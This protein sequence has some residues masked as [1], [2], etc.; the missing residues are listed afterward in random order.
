M[1]GAVGAPAA[2]IGAVMCLW[3]VLPQDQSLLIVGT[4]YLLPG[5]CILLV[6]QVFVHLRRKSM[7]GPS[8]PDSARDGIALIAVLILLALLSGLVT[9]SLVFASLALRSSET[10]ADRSRVRLAASDAM[11]LG[12]RRLVGTSARPAPVLLQDPSGI[13]ARVRISAKSN[14]ASGASPGIGT[15]FTLRASASGPD[16]TAHIYCRARREASGDLR[17]VRWVEK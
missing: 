16:A 5:L 14:P 2:V 10:E 8:G 9:H 17:V 15:D 13:E 6:R 12:L 7:S 4:C 1:L 3:A 11:W